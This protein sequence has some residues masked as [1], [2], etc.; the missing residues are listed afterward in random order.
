MPA[1]FGP[2]TVPSSMT[3]NQVPGYSGATLATALALAEPMAK[4]GK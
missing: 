1:T 2:S 3:P 4:I